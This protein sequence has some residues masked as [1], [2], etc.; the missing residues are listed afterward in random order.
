MRGLHIFLCCGLLSRSLFAARL[1]HAASAADLIAGSEGFRDAQ[2][3]WLRTGIMSNKTIFPGL[4]GTRAP[5]LDFRIKHRLPFRH[6]SA[7]CWDVALTPNGV[8]IFHDLILRMPELHNISVCSGAK[9]TAG[10]D[11]HKPKRS[12]GGSGFSL[13]VDP[14][15]CRGAALYNENVE[16]ISTAGF[17]QYDDGWRLIEGSAA[18][19]YQGWT[20]RSGM[21]SQPV[22]LSAVDSGFRKAARGLTGSVSAY[23]PSFWPFAPVRNRADFA[24][25]VC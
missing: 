18:K 8:N 14:A 3:F 2:Q 22:K 13:E 19:S 6:Q 11:R 25:P 23:M 20:T 4:P 24:T 10:S 7:P 9:R 16:Y 17:R 15:E 1:S 21:P 5:R 12:A